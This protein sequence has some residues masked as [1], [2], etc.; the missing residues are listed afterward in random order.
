VVDIILQHSD[1]DTAYSSK[2]MKR[3]LQ[4]YFGDAVTFSHSVRLRGKCD[5]ITLKETTFSI[6]NAF[7]REKNG[8]TE[9]SEK[10]R[11]IT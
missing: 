6:I 11:I 3:K 4:E 2:H 9:E 8:A 7:A 1:G 5:I 10:D